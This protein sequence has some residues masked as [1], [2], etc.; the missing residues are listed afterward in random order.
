[1]MEEWF[2]TS[3]STVQRQGE[4]SVLFQN[5]H[6]D[7]FETL[8]HYTLVNPKT[9]SGPNNLYNQERVL[10]P[11]FR[12]DLEK[13]LLVTHRQT[14]HGVDKGGVGSEGGE[15]DGS[16]RGKNPR[17]YRVAFPVQAGPRP[18]PVEMCSGRASMQTAM[19]VHFCHRH[20][21]D[22]VMIMEE[23][24]L[25]HPRCPLCDIMVPWK[26]LNVA[27]R[28]T[29]QCNRGVEQKRR[30]LVAEKEREV[31]NRAFSAYGHPLEMVTSF[32]YL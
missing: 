30:R 10:C 18:R 19:R 29:A 2:P 24:N 17:T 15:A 22:T 23:G 5:Q 9:L 16:N 14:Q 31:T 13:G 6:G 21:R 8:S 11:E 26:A 20:V 25:P 7:S 3:L 28:H 32:R 4:P 27:H 1:M 12:T